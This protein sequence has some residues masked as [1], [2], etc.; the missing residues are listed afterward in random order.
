[1]ISRL[2]SWT[3]TLFWVAAFGALMNPPPY[4]AIA[5]L[6]FSMGLVLLPSTDKLTQRYWQSKIKGGTKGAIVLTCLIIICLIVPQV[7][8]DPA[9]Y[10]SQSMDNLRSSLKL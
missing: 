3:A 8:T 4:I 10:S 1:M 5:F 7:E 2:N 6:F 9:R